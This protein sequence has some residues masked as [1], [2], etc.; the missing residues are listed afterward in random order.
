M[1]CL[2]VVYG[3]QKRSWGIARTPTSSMA[4]AKLVH[5]DMCLDPQWSLKPLPEQIQCLQ[6]AY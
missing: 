2:L 6:V 3:R 4:Q 5:E 1:P